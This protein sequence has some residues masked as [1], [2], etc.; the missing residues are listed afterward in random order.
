MS[1]WGLLG[2]FRFPFT[3]FPRRFLFSPESPCTMRLGIFGG[4][5]DPVHYGHLLLAEWAREQAGLDE[6]WLMP[7]CQSPHKATGAHASND[8]RAQMLELACEDNPALR[9]SRIELERGGVSYTAETLAGVAAERPGDDLFLLMGADSLFDL[10][11]WRKPRE[12]C[13]LATPLVAR[14]YDQPELDFMVLAGIA[15][16]ETVALAESVRLFMPVVD[17]SS[18]EIRRRVKAGESIRYQTPT[19]VIDYI[20]QHRLYR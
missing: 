19:V 18:T 10:P 12:I 14:R 16:P 5:F 13:R 4:S 7:A 11:T 1:A 20:D 8:A 3:R 9:V 15:S 17:L 6:V 2:K